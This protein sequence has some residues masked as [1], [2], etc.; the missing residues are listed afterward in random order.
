MSDTLLLSFEASKT[1]EADETAERIE[2]NTQLKEEVADLRE[3]VSTLE[4][5]L[6]LYEA[7]AIEQEQQLQGAMVELKEHAQLLEHAQEALQTLQTT[8][9]SMG[10]AVIVAGRDGQ[11]LFVNPAAQRLL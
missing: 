10:D 7:S 6:Q 2:H 3:Q 1:A 11:A 8:L 4:E 5:L 9:D